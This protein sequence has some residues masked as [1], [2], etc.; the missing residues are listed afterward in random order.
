[1]LPMPPARQRRLWN[2]AAD[3]KQKL[4]QAALDCGAVRAARVASDQIL[5]SET[6]R[7]IC[8]GN[9][10]GCYGRCW[11][12]PPQI[13]PIG[14]LIARAK[15]YPWGVLYQTVSPLEDSFDFEGMMEAAGRHARVSQELQKI[16]AGLLAEPFLH[17]S[18][19]GCHL[20]PVC[21]KRTDEPCRHPEKALPSLEGYG[22]DVYNTAGAAG[23]PYINGANTVTYFGM[24]LFSE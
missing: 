8:R 20:C 6:F 4:I 12:C 11:V 10:C 2:S 19:G 7:E 14:E 21:A 16:A 3:M 17:L 9:Q 24:I 15:E 18:C 13:G 22:V 5:F 1:M 23:L